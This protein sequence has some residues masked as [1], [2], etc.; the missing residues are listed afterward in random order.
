MRQLIWT[1]LLASIACSTVQ[2][3]D[4]VT[5]ADL[6]APTPPEIIAL[7]V[8]TGTPL[9]VVLDKELRIHKVGQP[10]QGKIAEPVYAFDKLVVPA[11]S[12]LIGRVSRIGSV[13]RQR[14]TAAAL[15]ANFSPSRDIQ[16]DFHELVLPD[17]R[18]AA[19]HTLVS[20]ASHGVLQFAT[21]DA[22]D[23]SEKG[24]G[25]DAKELASKKVSE[26]AGN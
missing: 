10:V 8:P 21:S 24:K 25:N 22:K 6:S 16:L 12:K 9:P 15:N 3:Q 17:G 7:T 20:P 18:H 11:G 13:S 2:G 5:R 4:E 23:K 1:V 26:A 14:R 19:I